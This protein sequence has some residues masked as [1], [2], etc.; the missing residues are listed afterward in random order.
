MW[1]NIYKSD[2][3]VAQ[4]Y[5]WTA[6]AKNGKTLAHS[7]MLSS[8]QACTNAIATV[9]AEAASGLVYDETGEVPAG[10]TISV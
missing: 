7:E 8:K 2:K 9:K 1:F 5:W 4:K 3:N 10:R 6:V